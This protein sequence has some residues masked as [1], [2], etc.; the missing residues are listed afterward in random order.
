MIKQSDV[1]LVDTQDEALEIAIRLRRAM[2]ASAEN[3]CTQ[4]EMHVRQRYSW[5]S[6][7]TCRKLR[8]IARVRRLVANKHLF[9][10]HV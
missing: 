3:F 5:S 6:A 1:S 7:G 9:D 10:L 4:A 2:G 8:L